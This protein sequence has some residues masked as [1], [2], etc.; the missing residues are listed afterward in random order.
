[1]NG[2][3][4]VIL[5]L[6]DIDGTLLHAHGSGRAAFDAVIAAQH[7]VTD[8]SRGI[9]YGGKTDPLILDEILTA[10]RGHAATA[11]EHAA[12][13]AAYVRELERLLADTGAEVIDGVTAALTFLAERRDVRLGIATGNVKAG[14][15]AKLAAAG[16]A[17]W[18][19]RD[20]IGGYGSDSPRRAELVAAAIAR[21]PDASQVVVVGDTI[22]DIAAARACDAIAVA[23]A[24][25][26]DS[27][28]ALAD[29]D[30]V[31]DSLHALPAWHARRFS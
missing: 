22:Y 30:I 29:A 3:R 4:R 20:P 25:G 6:F 1:M 17:H 12:F 8:A 13:I 15:D 11:D 7:G 24:T 31:L 21:A 19:A 2:G 26:S 27:H 14:A 28:L 16:L 9:R 10:R 23:V 5:Y 18:F